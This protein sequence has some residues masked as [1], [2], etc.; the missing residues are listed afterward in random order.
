MGYFMR[1]GALTAFDSLLG[2]M[3][4]APAVQLLCDDQANQI[5]VFR[6]NLVDSLEIAAVVDKHKP[7]HSDQL[8]LARACG[9]LVL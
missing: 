6:N 9:C 3:M 7:L 8:A 1:G 5:V 2:Q 4:G